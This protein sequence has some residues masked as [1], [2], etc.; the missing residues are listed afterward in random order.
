MNIN[1][2]RRSS[3][4]TRIWTLPPVP[5]HCFPR[6]L[7]AGE[8]D[9]QLWPETIP[10]RHSTGN[11]AVR[12]VIGTKLCGEA[13]EASFLRKWGILVLEAVESIIDSMEK[14]KM[15]FID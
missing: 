12:R 4:T 8:S 3:T 9:G 1:N 15:F 13:A 5:N 11:W 10:V 7:G 2:F 6:P 14:N